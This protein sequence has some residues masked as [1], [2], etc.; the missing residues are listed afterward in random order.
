MFFQMGNGPEIPLRSTVTITREERIR[1]CNRLGA[2]SGGVGAK[3]RQCDAVVT[4]IFHVPASRKAGMVCLRAALLSV[5]T[6]SL[7]VFA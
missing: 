7:T 6:D 3:G 4:P 5:C 2:Q 1:W